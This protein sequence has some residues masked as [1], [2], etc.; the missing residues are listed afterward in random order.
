M[1]LYSLNSC[2][3]FSRYGRINVTQTH[4]WFLLTERILTISRKNKGVASEGMVPALEKERVA[5]TADS[6]TDLFGVMKIF[7]KTMLE[8]HRK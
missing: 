5:E 8:G 1:F 7:M 3:H 2:I 4:E 6:T